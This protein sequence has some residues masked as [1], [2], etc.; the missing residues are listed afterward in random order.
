VNFKFTEAKLSQ[1]QG[2]IRK[3]SHTDEQRVNKAKNVRSV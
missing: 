1:K 2:D 3:E